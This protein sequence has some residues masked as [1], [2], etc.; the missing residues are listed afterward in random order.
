MKF[1]PTTIP[2]E[3]AQ[4]LGSR[5]FQIAEIARIYDVP[6]ILLQSHEKAR[7]LGHR[8]RAADDRLRAADDRALGRR[9]GA[10]AELEAVH[11]RPSASAGYYVKF[12][13]N[14]CCAATWRRARPSTRP[15]SR[16]AA[17]RRT[18]SRAL[19]DWEPI[20]PEGDNRFVPANFVTLKQAIGAPPAPVTPVP[21]EPAPEPESEAA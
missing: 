21:F 20:G 18:R 11:R 12:N 14:A 15:C 6:L 2:P 10:G 19:E 13:M 16:S 17:S 7:R 9:L 5:E 8:H 1:I 4:F 3:D